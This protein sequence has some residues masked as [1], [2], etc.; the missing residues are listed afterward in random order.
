[1]SSA[2]TDSHKAALQN[3]RV[4]FPFGFAQALLHGFSVVGL[5]L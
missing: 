5:Y 4:R 3:Q 1:M 2:T